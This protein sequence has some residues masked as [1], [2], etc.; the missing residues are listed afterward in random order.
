MN[1][2]IH[3]FYNLFH[4]AVNTGL[5]REILSQNAAAIVRCIAQLQLSMLSQSRDFD[6]QPR[7]ASC[8]RAQLREDLNIG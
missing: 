4:T 3:R 1:L 8:S 7:R 2:S 6:L 5:V